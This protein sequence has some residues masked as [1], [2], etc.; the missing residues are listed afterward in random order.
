MQRFHNVETPPR[1]WGRPVSASIT[2]IGRRNTPTGVGKTSLPQK[3][4]NKTR[5]HPHGRGEDIFFCLKID[6]F[7]ETPP[8]AWG[9]LTQSLVRCNALRNTPTGVGKTFP[10]LMALRTRQKHPHGRGEDFDNNAGDS[11]HTETPPRAW[12]RRKNQAEIFKAYRNTPTGVGKTI[13]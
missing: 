3:R 2:A 8:R 12:G 1:A 4:P 6:L 7:S 9:R 13:A 10:H 11:A 5:K